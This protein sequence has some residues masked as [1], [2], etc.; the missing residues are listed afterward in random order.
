MRPPPRS[1]A[2]RSATASSE[3]SVMFVAASRVGSAIGNVRPEDPLVE[4]WVTKE[5]RGVRRVLLRLN[6]G[7]DERRG[8]GEQR[9]CDDEGCPPEKPGEDPAGIGLARR[10]RSLRPRCYRLSRSGP[11]T[12][13]P[14]RSLGASPLPWTRVSVKLISTAVTGRDESWRARAAAR[15]EGDRSGLR[16]GRSRSSTRSTSGASTGSSATGWARMLMRRT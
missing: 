13:P 8:G 6:E 4:A 10:T 9:A 11:S 2:V 7:E 16:G 1:A 12:R 15:G 3:T 5:Q 14:S